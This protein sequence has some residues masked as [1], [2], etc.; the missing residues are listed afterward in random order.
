MKASYPHPNDV[1]VLSAQTG[2]Q[3][4]MDGVQERSEKGD[5]VR[6]RFWPLQRPILRMMRSTVSINAFSFPS[7]CF[8]ASYPPR[9]AR[10]AALLKK[11]LGVEVE[12]VAGANGEFTVWVDDKLVARKSW[13]RFPSDQRVLEAV[14]SAF[15]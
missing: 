13:V 1:A 8:W 12:T 2:T 14:R 6:V 11:E 4:V 7:V 10:V 3:S 9:A 15:G 5:L